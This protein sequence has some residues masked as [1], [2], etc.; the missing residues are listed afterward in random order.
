MTAQ[1][2][3]DSLFDGPATDKGTEDINV[4]QSFAI[5][6]SHDQK[7]SEH[8]DD[9]IE[10]N[11]DRSKEAG[12]GG[13]NQNN[14]D[15]STVISNQI[16]HKS[17]DKHITENNQPSDKKKIKDQNEGL[18]VIKD[19]EKKENNS[20]SRKMKSTSRKRPQNHLKIGS[21]FLIYYPQF[22]ED[23]AK[24]KAPE[25]S[26]LPPAIKIKQTK[27]E[28]ET[29]ILSMFYS[30]SKKTTYYLIDYNE[31]EVWRRYSHFTELA[32]SLAKKYPGRMIPH[33]PPK[34]QELDQRK[35]NLG[36]FLIKLITHPFLKSTTEVEQFLQVE[37]VKSYYYS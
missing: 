28:D 14:I 33:I 12:T 21:S 30:N 20:R 17:N 24:E 3:E 27:V 37:K 2:P 19:N 6:S 31:K 36:Y 25:D 9:R 22:I 32:Q 23:E 15:E 29:G 11:N 8:K 26:S 5:I 4:S 10:N 35:H 7:E 18:L 16:T 1:N 13:S 34:A